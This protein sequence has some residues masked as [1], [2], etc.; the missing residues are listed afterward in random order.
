MTSILEDCDIFYP[1]ML[2][3]IITEKTNQRAAILFYSDNPPNFLLDWVNL[4][5]LE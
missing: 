2:I 5:V 3:K 1:A 4:K